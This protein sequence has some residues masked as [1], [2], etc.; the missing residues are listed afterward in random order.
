MTET[1]GGLALMVAVLFGWALV[2][3]AQRSAGKREILCHETRYLVTAIR[4][5]SITASR[6]AVNGITEGTEGKQG[7]PLRD[8]HSCLHPPIVLQ[9][10]LG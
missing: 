7:F 4:T 3:S 10:W 2:F 5:G 6:R 8:S 9:S 1:I